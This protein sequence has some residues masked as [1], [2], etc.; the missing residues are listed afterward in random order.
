MAKKKKKRPDKK[1]LKKQEEN[2]KNEDMQKILSFTDNAFVADFDVENR[3]FH[4]SKDFYAAM[5][6]LIDD[7]GC[8]YVEA[9]NRLGFDTSILGEDRANSAGRRAMRKH[10]KGELDTASPGSYDGT[11]PM[12]D[13]LRILSVEEQNAYLIAR[14][15]YL[16]HLNDLQKKIFTTMEETDPSLLRNLLSE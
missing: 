14:N 10:E 6:H 15:I 3:R 2:R 12:D 16:E 5:Y 11:A 13:M 7:D 8:T 1:L 4:Y 9:Y